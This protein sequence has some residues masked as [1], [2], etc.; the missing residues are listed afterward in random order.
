MKN[1][2]SIYILLPVVLFIWGMV[3][4]RFFSYENPEISEAANYNTIN[5]KPSEPVVPDT[6]SIDVSYRDPFLGKNYLPARQ[7]G[8]IKKKT[9]K[10]PEL[11]WP[12]VLYKGLVT[13]KKDKRKVFMVVINGHTY[14]LNEKDTEQGITIK[15]GNRHAIT[16]SYQGNTKTIPIQ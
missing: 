14:L 8:A 16:V 12:Q 6:F 9:Q 2:K 4:Y 3:I 7:A 13:D 10:G 11:L 1:K 5:L 15:R